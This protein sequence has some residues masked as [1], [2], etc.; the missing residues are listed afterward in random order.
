M[1]KFKQK[2]HVPEKKNNDDKNYIFFVQENGTIRKNGNIIYFIH[3]IT[4]ILGK[5][6][7]IHLY[8]QC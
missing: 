8:K 6:L 7:S 3:V 2:L 4:V 1:A 5:Y